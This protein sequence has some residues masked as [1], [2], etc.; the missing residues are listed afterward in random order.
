CGRSA[1]IPHKLLTRAH[2]PWARVPGLPWT[3]SGARRARGGPCWRSGW[4][5]PPAGCPATRPCRWCRSPSCGG[6]G[7]R[8]SI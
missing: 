6:G 5:A 7:R 1:T 2:G 4:T 8:P 3:A